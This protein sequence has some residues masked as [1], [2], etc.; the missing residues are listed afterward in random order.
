MPQTANR[1]PAKADYV[2]E[3]RY[4]PPTGGPGA[5]RA[6]R[7]DK[8]DPDIVT[9]RVKSKRRIDRGGRLVETNG[10]IWCVEWSEGRLP[11]DGAWMCTCHRE[12]SGKLALPRLRTNQPTA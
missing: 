3:L 8:A 2:T 11:S 1:P 4:E 10:S 7:I 9:W 5:V 12:G 6:I